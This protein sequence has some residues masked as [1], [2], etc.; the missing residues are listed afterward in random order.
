VLIGAIVVVVQHL[1]LRPPTNSASIPVPLHPAHTLPDKPSIA[2]LP[3]SNLS[4]D[5]G[6]NYFSDG[7][8]DDLINHLS[9]IPSLFVIARTSSFTYKNKPA[10][11]QDIGRQLGVRYVLEGSV[12]KAGNRVRIAAQLADAEDGSELWAQSYDRPLREVFTMQDEIVER[13]LKTLRLQLSVL[14]SG[15]PLASIP[16]GTDNPDAYDYFLRASAPY[17]SGTKEG[18]AKAGEMCQ[19]AIEL[20]PKFSYAYSCLASSYDLE[21]RL[22]SSSN[23]ARDLQLATTLAQKTLSLDDSNPWGYY[24][25]SE[26][27]FTKD[28]LTEAAGDARRGIAL[29]PSGPFG[30]Q[31]LADAL[32]GMGKPAEGVEAVRKTMRLDPASDFYLI[33]IGWGYNAM[34]KYEATISALRQHLVQFPNDGWARINLA[35]AYSETHQK[36]LA[37]AEAA[38]ARRI[39]PNISLKTLRPDLWGDPA[40][41]ARFLSDLREAGLN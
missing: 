30:Y 1:P 15:L 23:P 21:V 28:N 40:L 2:V 39:N 24:V 5:P 41:F 26:L 18:A 11:V 19:H 4:G 20:D 34:R 33:E 10:R 32:I 8:T 38:E 9:R 36:E 17:F 16:H 35:I 13:I 25:L 22:G 12:H 14:Q 3:F 29:D 7:I 31:R 27:N 37:R 6:Q